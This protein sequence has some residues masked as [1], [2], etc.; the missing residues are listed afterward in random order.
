MKKVTIRL[1]ILASFYVLYRVF[2]PLEQPIL[3]EPPKEIHDDTRLDL[4]LPVFARLEQ[5]FSFVGKEF[6]YCS[7]LNNSTFDGSVY[8][9]SLGGSIAQRNPDSSWFYNLIDYRAAQVEKAIISQHSHSNKQD[10]KRFACYS[11]AIGDSHFVNISR[12]P[13]LISIDPITYFEPILPAINLKIDGKRKKFKLAFLI[14]VHELKGFG[15]LIRLLDVLDDGDAIILVHVDG[16]S[17]SEKLY[18]KIEDWISNRKILQNSNVHLAKFR[19]HNIWGHSSLVFTQLSGF[20]E[21][22][23]LADWDFVINLSNY[24]WPLKRNKQ[25]YDALELGKNYIEFWSE[26]GIS[27]K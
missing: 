13:L 4:S 3:N 22:K 20:W 16:K 1:L 10:V 6:K 12:Q 9:Y 5:N 24:D 2:S 25:V 23:E 15:N 8:I 14:M 7:I 11:T 27:L 26:N 17:S 21:L 18:L 19:L